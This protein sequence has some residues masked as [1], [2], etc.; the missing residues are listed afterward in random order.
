MDIR[1]EAKDEW[2]DL[3]RVELRAVAEEKGCRVTRSQIQEGTAGVELE[4]DWG[5]CLACANLY[6]ETIPCDRAS[7]SLYIIVHM[8]PNLQSASTHATTSF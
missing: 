1:E 7:S 5:S 6:A 2:Q 4:G 3:V 8:H